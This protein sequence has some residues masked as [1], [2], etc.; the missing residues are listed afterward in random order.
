MGAL[1]GLVPI[2]GA[3]SFYTSSGFSFPTPRTD[4]FP[5]NEGTF[6]I[7]DTASLTFTKLGSNY[8]GDAPVAPLLYRSFNLAPEKPPAATTL[9]Y[10]VR[11]LCSPD[12][13]NATVLNDKGEVAGLGINGDP[14]PFAIYSGTGL[15]RLQLPPGA[16]PAHMNGSGVI[17]GAYPV[18]AGYPAPPGAVYYHAFAY[19]PQPPQLYELNSAFGQVS[20][21]ATWINNRGD[22]SGGSIPRQSIFGLDFISEIYGI[23]DPGVL[24]AGQ[25]VDTPSGRLDRIV[26]A[27]PGLPPLYLPYYWRLPSFNNSGQLVG[28]D[29]AND[30]APFLY[31]PD[32]GPVPL[33]ADVVARR[34]SER[35]IAINDSGLIV[36]STRGANT[37]IY[38]SSGRTSGLTQLPVPLHSFVPPESGWTNF[39]PVALNNAGQILVQALNTAGGKKTALLFFPSGFAPEKQ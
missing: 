28:I 31:T 11:D 25:T 37:L 38:D 27:R 26:I 23:T 6:N 18:P 22:I 30:Y 12:T 24:I 9:S 10:T 16:V 32:V 4:P 1:A 21:V 39:V 36:F 20:V 34:F 15:T 7:L 8:W 3:A 13:C 14:I 35:P 17:V 5:P 2:P 29:F 19:V 33:P